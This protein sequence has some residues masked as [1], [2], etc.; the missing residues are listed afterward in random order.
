MSSIKDLLDFLEPHCQ[1]DPARLALMR[2]VLD[3]NSPLMSQIEISGNAHTFSVNL[4]SKLAPHRSARDALIDALK[5]RY[6]SDYE[7]DF[8]QLRLVLHDWAERGAASAELTAARRLAIVIL[9]A[10][11]D[12]LAARLNDQLPQHGFDV[13]RAN[14]LSFAD[15]VIAVDHA[16]TSQARANCKPIIYL[17]HTADAAPHA[18]ALDL[19]TATD[20][21]PLIAAL[22][23]PTERLGRLFG[24]PPLPDHYIRRQEPLDAVVHSLT[25]ERTNV[26]A[27]CAVHGMP[28]I[29]KSVLARAALDSCA[30]RRAFPDGLFYLNVSDR[31]YVAA[32]KNLAQR[33]G[34]PID[35]FTDRIEDNRA[36]LADLIEE[37]RLRLLILL[38]NVRDAKAVEAF[39]NLRGCKVL[40]TTRKE[41][42]ARALQAALTSLSVL[43]DAE[44][45]QLILK[46]LGFTDSPSD[47][48]ADSADVQNLA[49]ELSRTLRGHPL[50]ISLAAAR[51]QRKGIA[52]GKQLLDEY[53]V[54]LQDVPAGDPLDVFEPDEDLDQELGEATEALKPNLER[55]FQ[56]SYDELSDDNKRRFRELGIFAVESRFDAQAAAAIWQDD[57]PQVAQSK[58]ETFT[59]LALLSRTDDG[60]FTQHSLLRAYAF[61][62]LREPSGGFNGARRRHFE[63]FFERR[64]A[65]RVDRVLLSAELPN[66]LLAFRFGIDHDE[67]AVIDWV[68]KLA[69]PMRGINR[70]ERRAILELGLEAARRAQNRDAEAFCL[71]A[72]CDVARDP[73]ERQALTEAFRAAV[74]GS[75]NVRILQMSALLES[76]LGNVTEARR[77]FERAVQADP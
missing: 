39:Q 38:D 27:I 2:E 3:V 61:K 70:A 7:R 49:M 45:A 6:G 12:A 76:R 58:L 35:N 8:E 29:G 72:L 32:Q 11:D 53:A 67:D 73:A 22:R 63:Y 42:I 9:A 23:K 69:K 36:L 21:K 4:L 46:F 47:Q 43:S 37:K 52:Q 19:R 30:V 5:D 13:L 14:E 68:R 51:W 1:T 77:L 26:A 34:L 17:W 48:R 71:H 31:N 28:G 50:A 18:E 75:C 64:K 20:L 59:R 57:D 74:R 10:P 33:L 16:D 62:K 60:R 44:G 65:Q 25:D 54:L 55:I 66:I 40:F 41:T 56:L 15:R 24:A